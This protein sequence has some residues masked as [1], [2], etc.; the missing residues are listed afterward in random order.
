M[1]YAK[2]PEISIVKFTKCDLYHVLKNVLYLLNKYGEKDANERNRQ[3]ADG[4]VQKGSNGS[5]GK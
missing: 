5:Q 2:R 3:D 4:R 1:D